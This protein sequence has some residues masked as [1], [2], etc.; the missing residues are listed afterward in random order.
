MLLVSNYVSLPL[1]LAVAPG[2]TAMPQSAKVVNMFRFFGGSTYSPLR[3]SYLVV[4]PIAFGAASPALS[5]QPSAPSE[6]IA[7]IHELRV[8]DPSLI[9]TSVDPCDDFYQFSCRNWFKRNPLP[10][11][12]T[13][14]GRFTE[15][16]EL[17]RL[18]LKGILEAASL[19]PTSSVPG[20]ARSTSEQKIGDEYATCM[21]VAEINQA[22]HLLAEHVK[23]HHA[24]KAAELNAAEKAEK[25]TNG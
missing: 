6:P 24:A 9:D 19:A 16:E 17:N 13:S 1:Y 3:I 22:G 11:D 23:G 4:F 18:Q 10:A 20:S 15:L 2:I 25:E 21:D 12:Q 5:Q 14:Y 8:F 7:S